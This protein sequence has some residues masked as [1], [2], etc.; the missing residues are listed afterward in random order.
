MSQI[1]LITGCSRGLGKL[2]TETLT[3]K[4]FIVYAGLRKPGDVKRLKSLWKDSHP[5]IHTMKLD[6]TVEEDCKKAIR[7]IVVNEGRID[8]LINNAGYTL[9]GPVNGFTAQEYLDILNTNTVGTFRLIQ[10]VV[11]QMRS[12][13]AGRII[14]I[15]SLNGLLVFPN[16]GLYSSSKFAL[17][18]LGLALRYE[19]KN[20]SIWVT[21][22]E[23]GAIATESA[24]PKK[25]S[26]VPVREKFWL[27]RKLMPMVTQEKVIKKIEKVINSSRPPARVIIG[28]D[29]KV[30]TF[31]QRFLP[32]RLW[33]F[34]L[35]LIWKR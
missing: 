20:S 3:S 18:A 34:L 29:A 21:N 11:P 1:V 17:E 7:E 12:Q 8:I 24:P 6:I 5:T 2:L 28:R 25:F 26:H 13:K 30:T 10:E 14:N 27:I 35:S 23:P 9:A 15:T 32:Q 4:G 16:F 33:D 31:L 22:V 19:L